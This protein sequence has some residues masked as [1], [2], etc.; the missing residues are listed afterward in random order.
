VHDDVV[1]LAGVI[2]DCHEES[3]QSSRSLCINNDHG[4]PT[5]SESEPNE[6]MNGMYRIRTATTEPSGA[7]IRARAM[8]IFDVVADVKNYSRVESESE[9]GRSV[10]QMK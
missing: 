7:T 1:Q 2:V 5:H 8:A 4:A 6:S 3:R 10:R 9:S